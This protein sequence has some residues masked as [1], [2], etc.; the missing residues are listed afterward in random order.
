MSTY[1]G[2]EDAREKYQT[3]ELDYFDGSTWK[4][5]L[6]VLNGRLCHHCNQLGRSEEK[7]MSY[8]SA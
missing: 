5:Q 3:V 7:D 6:A 1:P 8:Q 2:T 4:I